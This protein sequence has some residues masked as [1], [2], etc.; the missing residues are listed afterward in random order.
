MEEKITKVIQ[1]ELAEGVEQESSKRILRLGE[2][3]K[4]INTQM[5]NIKKTNIITSLKNNN[6]SKAQRLL[7]YLDNVNT[8]TYNK[9]IIE[10]EVNSEII[11]QSI[12]KLYFLTEEFFALRNVINRPK[13]MMTAIDKESGMYFRK[14][15]E[16]ELLE[17]GSKY[18]APEQS[19]KG[20]GIS[21]RFQKNAIIE[22]MKKIIKE[23]EQE[24]ETA[25]QLY[26]HYKA[27]TEPYFRDER[28]S[29][30]G[31]ARE[32]FERHLENLHKSLGKDGKFV[33]CNMESEGR[34]WIL[35]RQSSGSDPYFTGPDTALSQVK[36]ANASLIS[37][38]NTVLNTA[39]FI[40]QEGLK[41]NSANLKNALRT[42]GED[43][44]RD[45]SKK[46]WDSL[47][48]NVQKEIEK[49][50]DG[51]VKSLKNRIVIK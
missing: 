37:N 14:D 30:E 21:L 12:T 41:I 39:E 11:I 3:V 40:V 49:E 6:K 29:N 4:E 36:A 38:I 17:N 15:F 1:S 5:E 18:L 9:E 46:L 27:F 47:S 28:N 34:R 24:V 22:Q 20:N 26:E 25:K 7:R 51:T 48:S 8:A 50:L 35:Y 44:I 16:I 32:A 45:F 42:K 43:E 19:S 13:F 31:I 2:I 23:N 10:N 33:E